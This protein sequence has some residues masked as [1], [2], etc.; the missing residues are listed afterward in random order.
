MYVS[1]LRPE[2]PPRECGVYAI[3]DLDRPAVKIGVASDR[4][5]RLRALRHASGLDLAVVAWI[6][7][8]ERAAAF[9]LEATLHE[10]FASARIP[11]TEWF[12]LTP[13][14]ETWIAEA[15]V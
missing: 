7:A 14:I 9:L 2:L 15:A 1:P 12:H 8:T 13:E 4:Q 5:R 10:R 11:R 3:R 6:T